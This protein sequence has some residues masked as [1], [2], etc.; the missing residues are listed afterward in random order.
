MYYPKFS[1]EFNHIEYFWCDGKSYTCKNCTYTIEGLREIVPAALKNIK[2]STILEY[3]N[4]CMEKMDRYREGVEYGSLQWKKLTSH[5][6]PWNKGDD[7][8]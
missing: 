3:Y 5:Q 1:Y 7:N 8:R 6:K 2:H 4:S